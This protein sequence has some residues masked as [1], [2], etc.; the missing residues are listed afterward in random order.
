MISIYDD[1]SLTIFCCVAAALFGAAMGSFLN[2]AAGRIAKEQSFLKGRSF[3]PACGHTLGAPDLIPVLSW[4]FLRGKCRYCGAK[5]SARYVLTELLFAALT[6]LCLLRFDLTVL[7]LRNWI[8]LCC[9]FCLSLTDFD[10]MIIPNGSLLIAA[11]AWVLA[12]PFLFDGWT[13]LLAHVLT[14]L[15]VSIGLYLL[16]LLLTRLLKKESLGFGD[17]KLFAVMGL[18]L[19]L[20]PSLFALILSC[21][22]GLLVN[23]PLRR[24]RSSG[25]PFPF[26][27][28]IAAGTCIM[29]FF[30]EQIVGWYCGVVGLPGFPSFLL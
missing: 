13:V 30:G 6:V 23:L 24:L 20:L 9:L 8:L 5:I 7:C 26:G 19:G 22:L 21:I 14:A 3:C 16:S 12:E 25:E 29:L 27:P 10:A 18:Y 28:W 11:A 1:P 2:C 15:G 4:V 17:V